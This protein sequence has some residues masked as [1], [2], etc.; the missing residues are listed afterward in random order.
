M[1]STFRLALLLSLLALAAAACGGDN[2]TDA[3]T[4]SAAALTTTSSTTTS[5]TNPPVTTTEAGASTLT[6]TGTE[7]IQ[8]GPSEVGSFVQFA[9][10][11]DASADVVMMFVKLTDI[12]LEDLVSDVERFPGID[13]WP[14]T[15]SHKETE[16][17]THKVVESGEDLSLAVSFKEPG[18]YG[19]IC[20]PLDST[21]PI[22]GGLL[23]VEA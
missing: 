18:Q 7:C 2:G 10:R 13:Q 22:P 21:P 19:T 9:L 23:T 5:T 8:A 14:P 6:F 12:S 11:N 17:V 15:V 20:L 4:T 3:T 1:T 16:T